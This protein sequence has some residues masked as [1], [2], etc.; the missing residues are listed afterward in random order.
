MRA[1]DSLDDAWAALRREAYPRDRL[2]PEREAS[3]L[4]RARGRRPW[5]R[6]PRIL[7]VGA[8]LGLCGFVAGG[9]VEKVRRWLVRMDLVRADGAPAD[10][11]VREV[12]E[13]PDGGTTFDLQVGAGAAEV[14]VSPQDE[15]GRQRVEVDLR[16]DGD[17]RGVIE[18]Q[19]RPAR[20]EK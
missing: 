16:N 3:L 12:R 11:R 17:E 15:S 7:A 19:R 6:A 14:R 5:R 20:E 2:P 10:G 18:I 9:G 13:D 4:L 1:R 8:L